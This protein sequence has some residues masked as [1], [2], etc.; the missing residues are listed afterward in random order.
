MNQVEGV[1][2]EHARLDESTILIVD[3]D[4]DLSEAL[5]DVLRSEGYAVTLAS[6]G[7]EAFG[8]L[9]SL[10]SPCGIIL[11]MAMPIMS[12][13]A[14]YQAMSAVPAFADIPVV[15]FASDPSCAPDGLTKISKTSPRLLLAVLATLF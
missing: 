4:A 7:K 15:V 3:D 14:F 11:D 8:L 12:G 2:R 9:P 6:N 5:S 10:K 13:T 1:G